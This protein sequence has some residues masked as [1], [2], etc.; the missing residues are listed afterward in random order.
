MQ[1]LFLYDTNLSFA[2]KNQVGQ[3]DVGD[4]A[5]FKINSLNDKFKGVYVKYTENKEIT[6]KIKCPLCNKYHYYTYNLDTFFKREITIGGC[7][8]LGEQIF[9][10]GHT[11]KVA[12]VINKYINIKSKVYAML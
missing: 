6:F 10:I 3:Y 5:L 11:E 2:L 9:L 7:E 4:F 8:L 12:G 1:I